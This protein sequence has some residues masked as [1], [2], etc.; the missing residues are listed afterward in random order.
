M[1]TEIDILAITEMTAKESGHPEIMYLSYPVYMW[2]LYSIGQAKYKP[3]IKGQR[4]VRR[5]KK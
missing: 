5:S 2:F 4:R 1:S 3:R